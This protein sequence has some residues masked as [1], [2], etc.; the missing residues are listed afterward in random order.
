MSPE[1]FMREYWQKK[2]L[3]VRN[4]IPTFS[5]G[6]AIG[7]AF[8][9]P[10][11]A[12]ELTEIAGFD[13]VESRLVQAKPWRLE[14]GPFSRKKIPAFHEADWT[15][16]L[17][18]MEAHHPA[19]ATILS[20]FRF[21]PDSR[22]DDLM[23]SLAGPGG[24]VGPHLDSYDVFLIQM[25]GRRHWKIS[26]Q[27]NH[28]LLPDLPLKIL[29]DFK[30]EQEWVLDPGDLLYLPPKIAHDGIALDPGTQTWS[31][32]FR[33]PSWKEL[34]QEVLWGMAES[35]EKDPSIAGLFSDP[36]QKATSNPAKLPKELIKEL[37]NKIRKLP[38]SGKNL[39]SVLENSLGKILS[40]PKPSVFFDA[41][42]TL[43]SQSQFTKACALHG[44][45]AS[46]KTRLTLTSQA[47]FCN[48]EE[49]LNA[50]KSGKTFKNW[51]KFS[52]NRSFTSNEC[53]KLAQDDPNFFDLGYEGYECGWFEVGSP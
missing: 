28:D 33:A 25:S 49:F 46:P 22:L 12:T 45:K 34:V 30:K 15:I 43:L 3:L 38:L 35:L 36:W 50:T 4:A 18:G 21:I 44:L 31:V 48:G 7:E 16:L 10:I 11:S 53:K 52:Q 27:K 39:H 13:E 5:L 47:L 8:E 19:A 40:E 20:W 14:H 37:E 29:A 51:S 2:P 32:G 26:A 41:P 9:S 17:Q 24:G 1:K 23:I 6:K 42:E